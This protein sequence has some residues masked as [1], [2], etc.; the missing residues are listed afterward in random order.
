MLNDAVL[1]YHTNTY[2]CGVARFNQQL[3]ARLGVP[4]LAL[5]RG[6]ACEAPLISVHLHEIPT[7]FYRHIP[8]TTYDLLLHDWDR[9]ARGIDWVRGARRVFGAN[10]VIQRE[11]RAWREDAQAVWCPS[12]VERR[13]RGSL[14]ETYQVLTFGMAHKLQL[15]LYRHLKRLL[16]AMGVWYTV[17][18]STAVHEGSPWD[19]IGQVAEAM[20]SVFEDHVKILGYL[21]DDGLT[22]ALQGAQLVAI[23]FVP[24]ARANNTTLWAAM[25]AGRPVITNLDADSPPELVHGQTVWDLHETVPTDFF[26]DRVSLSP[27]RAV[28]HYRWDGLVERLKAPVLV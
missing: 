26:A 21:A 25:E 2:A 15:D 11:I 7:G 18:V 17:S 5:A 12:T 9:S 24:A 20:R 27:F 22:D 13:A 10:P 14:S 16:D 3:A 8:F 19:A 28:Q 1:T 6:A 4:C 23:F